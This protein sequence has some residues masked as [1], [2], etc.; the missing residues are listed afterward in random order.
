M[1][2][3][4]YSLWRALCFDEPELPRYLEIARAHRARLVR[5]AAALADELAA[6]RNELGAIRD[7]RAHLAAFRALGLQPS[8]ASRAA[9]ELAAAPRAEWTDLAWRALDD[10]DAHRALL[11]QPALAGQLAALA[12]S[13]ICAS[14]TGDRDPARSPPSCRPSS[15]L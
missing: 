15:K 4:L 5:D 14:T 10:A 12:R 11:Q 7:V 3:A 1:P 9:D 6:G 8:R 13:A 2:T